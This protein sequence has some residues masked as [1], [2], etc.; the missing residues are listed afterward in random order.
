MIPESGVVHPWDEGKWIFPI[1]HPLA[2]I[3]R[4]AKARYDNKTH[5]NPQWAEGFKQGVLE[6][7]QKMLPRGDDD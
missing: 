5:S 6:A 2:A 3:E 7:G 4:Q 1:D